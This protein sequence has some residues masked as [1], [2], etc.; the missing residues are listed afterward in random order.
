MRRPRRTSLS[1][2]V[3]EASRSPL[4]TTASFVL[5]TAAVAVLLLFL[6]LVYARY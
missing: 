2:S 5:G 6:R 4:H 3:I 1:S